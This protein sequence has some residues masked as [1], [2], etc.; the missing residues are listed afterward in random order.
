M[1]SKAREF[2]VLETGRLALRAPLAS[3]AGAFGSILSIHDVTRY[4]NWVDDPTK[5]QLE[6]A[7]R[8]MRK[9]YASGAG[10]GWI[11]EERASGAVAGAIRFNNFEIKW[12]CGEIGYELH[13][14]FWGKGLM[15]EAVTPWRRAAMRSSG[16]TGSKPG[17]SP[18][19]RRRTGCWKSRAFAMKER[20]GNEDG[21][22]APITTSACLGG[23]RTTSQLEVPPRA[24]SPREIT[25][26][27][28]DSV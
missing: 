18:A 5:A 3:D 24:C 19:I 11:I 7:M 12:R 1:P 4:S 14:D 8:W 9:A 26:P 10:C 2:P 15:T 16:S 22:R 6:R 17:R 28:I 25:R 23:S 27:A 20:C 13:P 21:S